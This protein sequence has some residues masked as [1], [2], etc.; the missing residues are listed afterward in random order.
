MSFIAKNIH[1]G[2]SLGPEFTDL[3][4]ELEKG[5]LTSLLGPNG[6]GKSTL[7]RA[8]SGIIPLKQ[9]SLSFEGQSLNELSRNEF[10]KKIAY[11]PQINQNAP[12][13]VFQAIL[14]GRTPY[15]RFMPSKNDKKIVE[16]VMDKFSISDWKD[17]FIS[18]LSGGERQKVFLAKALAQTTPIIILDEPASSLDVRY[19]LELYDLLRELCAQEQKIILVA[20]HDLNLATR[21]SDTLYVM[22][23]KKFIAKGKPCDAINT[24][25]LKEVY[26]IHAEIETVGSSIRIKSTSRCV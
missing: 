13:Q 24:E 6:S 20:E 14:M 21:F 7:I 15:M 8:L 26:E 9:G 10:A 11:V 1:F 19:Q 4:L 12:V 3:S 23:Q 5:T 2:H 16:M 18:E 22:H 25:L 17:R